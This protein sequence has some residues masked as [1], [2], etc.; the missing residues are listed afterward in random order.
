M[1]SEVMVVRHEEPHLHHVVAAEG[2]PAGT[3]QVADL[4]DMLEVPLDASGTTA[5]KALRDT[6]EG[7][8]KVL[9][10]AA[11]KFRRARS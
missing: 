3:A 2:W 9:V 6:G 1:P 4:L 10:L 8:R 11:L 5:T 7:R